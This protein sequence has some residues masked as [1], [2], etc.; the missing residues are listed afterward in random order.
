MTV[1]AQSSW[2]LATLPLMYTSLHALLN[3]PLSSSTITGGMKG[4]GST[5]KFAMLA[6]LVGEGGVRARSSQV[7]EGGE[8]FAPGGGER[9]LYQ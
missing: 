4:S 5:T 8:F 6:E 9:G 1:M 2:D 7:G 3:G